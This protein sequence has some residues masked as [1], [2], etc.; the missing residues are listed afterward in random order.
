M[1]ER[2]KSKR[3]TLDSKLII[4]R[5]DGGEPA[6]VAVEIVDVSQSG[7]GFTADCLLETGQV[8]EMN[9]TIWTKEVLH[10]LVRIARIE[11]RE[12]EYVYGATFTGMSESDARRIAI[13]QTFHAES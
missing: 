5:L 2:R 12:T 6:E 13:Y 11:L 8:Y 4:K 3:T 9:L 7:L 1:E 10:V